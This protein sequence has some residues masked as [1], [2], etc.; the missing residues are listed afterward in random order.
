MLWG[1]GCSLLDR[2]PAILV[3]LQLQLCVSGEAGAGSQPGRGPLNPHCPL[4]WARAHALR[5]KVF[6]EAFCAR[7]FIASLNSSSDQTWEG[8][9]NIGGECE[10]GAAGLAQP[11]PTPRMGSGAQ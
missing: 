10:Q 11:Q 7:M 1:E 8:A 6:R 5:R 3:H 2:N 4:G 9:G